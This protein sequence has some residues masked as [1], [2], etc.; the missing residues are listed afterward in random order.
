MLVARP[1]KDAA[2]PCARARLVNAFW[3]LMEGGPA[4]EI[5]VGAVTRAAGC[6]RGTFYYHFKDIDELRKTAVS[7]MLLDDGALAD[8]VWRAAL[9]GDIDSLFEHGGSECLHRLVLALESGSAP[10]VNTIAR[11][12]VID[13]WT[14]AACT[15][16]EELAPD[17]RFAIQFMVSGVMSLMVAMGY[18]N[19]GV[20]PLPKI[21]LGPC[22]RD[23]LA[24]VALAT[25]DAVAKAQGI[26]RDDLAA[27]LSKAV[28]P[29]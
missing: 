6:N 18:S 28:P 22:A 25:L 9:E 26:D 27:R 16:G 4:A 23:Y 1:R 20:S 10:L 2:E 14:R 24:S 19:E 7:Q 3:A 15:D 5:S 17:A 13:R 21:E 29:A 12:T 11:T 8:G